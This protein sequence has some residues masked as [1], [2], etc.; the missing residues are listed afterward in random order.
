MKKLGRFILKLFGWK[1]VGELPPDKKY[2]VVVAPHT[3]NWDFAV[4]LFARFSVGVK[5][6]FWQKP[7]IF[8][9]FGPAPEGF[10]RSAS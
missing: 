8:L 10:G 1:V 4:G 6:N 7:V 2:M 3:S 9:P 5:I